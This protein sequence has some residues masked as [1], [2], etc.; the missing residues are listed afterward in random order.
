MLK[1]KKLL[2]AVAPLFFACGAKIERQAI[3]T[4]DFVEGDIPIGVAEVSAQIRD[5]V[6]GE[7]FV[8]GSTV[9]LP[10]KPI[11]PAYSEYRSFSV[12]VA[13]DDKNL[14]DSSKDDPAM[15]R[16]L[17]LPSEARK[18]DVY[19]FGGGT[20]W[21]SEYAANDKPVPFNCNFIVHLQED[22][23]GQTRVEVLEFN[24]RVRFGKVLRRVHVGF[25]Y[26]VNTILVSPTTRDRV[27]MLERIQTLATKRD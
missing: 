14:R 15:D 9:H 19:L 5:G 4:R 11:E 3:E 27:E 7:K 10:G 25:G 22:G 8:D 23:P 20:H 1:R 17:R 6:L 24:P 13:W 16:Y 26:V 12:G 2:I 18:D 21:Y